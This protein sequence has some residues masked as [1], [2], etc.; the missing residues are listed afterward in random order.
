MHVETRPWSCFW[1]YNFHHCPTVSLPRS[2]IKLLVAGHHLARK[3]HLHSKNFI[4]I[5]CS[6]TIMNYTQMDKLPW[7]D[8]KLQYTQW[9]L[10]LSVGAR[11]GILHSS[12]EKLHKRFE[13]TQSIL[14]HLPKLWT[15][16]YPDY[17]SVISSRSCWQII[18]WCFLVCVRELCL[19]WGP[20]VPR[21]Y[22]VCAGARLIIMISSCA[23]QQCSL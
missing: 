20:V 16:E 21:W 18:V 17:V 14:S 15:V 7:L 13:E 6:V 19:C 11:D 12:L 22:V 2:S 23:W 8:C 10:Q 3:L 1:V 4:I 9:W 5:N